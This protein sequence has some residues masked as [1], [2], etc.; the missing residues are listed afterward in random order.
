ME[1]TYKP[2]HLFHRGILLNLKTH[3]PLSFKTPRFLVRRYKRSDAALLC[4]AAQASIAQVF[5]F[6]PWCHPDYSIEDSFEWLNMVE[7]NWK[8]GSAYNFGIFSP[9]GTE[10]HGGCG[11]ARVDEHPVHNLGYWVKTASTGQKVA[12][13]VTVELARFG[14]K[15]LGLERIEIV[16]SVENPGSQQVA[17]G[18]KAQFEGTLR[19]RLMLHGRC[20]DAYLYSL[21]PEDMAINKSN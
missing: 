13:E 7:E 2:V 18:A 4:Q 11:L 12:T 3:I 9:D 19:N 21:T 16:M 6:L 5:E 14:L 20:H 15:S 10:F 1:R 8:S 17:I